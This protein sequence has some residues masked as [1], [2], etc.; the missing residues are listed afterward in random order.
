MFI[1]SFFIKMQY[2]NRIWALHFEVSVR[3]GW[4]NNSGFLTNIKFNRLIKDLY[5][6]SHSELRTLIFSVNVQLLAV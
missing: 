1:W 4:S 5:F 2:S 6:G 3:N